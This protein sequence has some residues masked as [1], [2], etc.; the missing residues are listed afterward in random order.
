MP[1]EG[2]FAAAEAGR[3]NTPEGIGQEVDRLLND[4]RGKAMLLSFHQRWFGIDTLAEIGKDTA[5]Y[6]QFD[7]KLIAS[8]QGEFNTF[9]NEVMGSKG[10]GKLET[11]LLSDRTYVD[12]PLAGLYGVPAPAGTGMQAVTLPTTRKGLLSTVSVLST[13]T[14]SDSSAAIHRGKFIRERLLCTVPPDPPAGLLVMPPEPKPG[15][16]TRERL[17][18]HTTDPSC[19]GCHQMMDPIGYAFENFDGIGRYRAMEQ[20][21]KIDASGSLSATDVD[22]PLVGPVE[23]AQ[24]LASS[25]TVRACVMTTLLSFAQGPQPVDTCL[26][27][28]L[29]KAFDD[30]GHDVRSLISAIAKSDS[31]R[32]RRQL[33]GE[34]LP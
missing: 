26:M 25:K 15:L 19:S 16:T 7:E 13:H 34:A 9:V 21:K 3:L 14:L 22:G 20:G 24:K 27:T 12:G 32:Y 2:L 1:D 28:K 30:S 31:F 23:L 6:P 10:D 17:T 11:L 8:M 18:Q 4:P 33:Q 5:V 29:N